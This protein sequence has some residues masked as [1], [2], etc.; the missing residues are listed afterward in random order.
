LDGKQH[1]LQYEQSFSGSKK[2]QID[3]NLAY[4]SQGLFNT[5]T[6]FP[7]EIDGHSIVLLIKPGL[8]D[9]Y[10][11]FVDD[12]SLI[13][14]KF[15]PDRVK[16]NETPDG[17]V[18]VY[19]GRRAVFGLVLFIGLVFVAVSV[20]MFTSMVGSGALTLADTMYLPLIFPIAGLVLVYW[21]LVKM[22]NKTT[23]AVSSY[24]VS[25]KQA[26]IPWFGNK[27]LPMA[28]IEELYCE[29]YER[30][31]RSGDGPVS[32]TMTFLLYRICARL[33]GGKKIT[34]LSD[35]DKCYE[36]LFVNRQLG[37]KLGKL[38]QPE[39]QHA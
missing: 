29:S 19:N 15:G 4:E 34:L 3:G 22:F 20:P 33:T 36:A 37:R 16:V 8:V 14:G 1:A 26:P 30:K 31:S 21:S 27:E 28:D 23:F 12:R 5:T 35:L 38:V 18:L 25:V 9:S 39:L 6:E 13:T 2:I 32:V 7:F 10:D 17:L 24:G 11:L